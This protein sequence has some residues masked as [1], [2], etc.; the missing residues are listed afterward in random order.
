MSQHKVGGELFHH[1]ASI[2]FIHRSGAAISRL[3]DGAN[4]NDELGSED[5]TKTT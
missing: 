5:L 1:R 4:E 3:D 2:H